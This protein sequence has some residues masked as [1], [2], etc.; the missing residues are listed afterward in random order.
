MKKI[1]LI[2]AGFGGQGVLFTGKLLAYCGILKN[3]Y[4]SFFPSY[5]PEMRGGTAN[6]GVIISQDEIES[7]I[8]ENPS[9]CIVMNKPSLDKFQQKIEKGGML[10]Y[11]R[12]LISESSFRK[13][14]EVIPVDANELA[15]SIGD[16]RV[17]NMIMVGAF[18]K[19]TNLFD[20]NLVKD[21][22]KRLIS[23]DKMSLMDLNLK[24][25]YKG[26]EK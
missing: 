5:G 17:A 24:A 14:I 9:H 7:P 21:I 8:V 18:T 26:R 22:L 12:S 16:L 13:D 3:L 6:C 11:N 19:K 2:V 20:Q 25:F 23:K 1:E 10:F 15:L 4:A